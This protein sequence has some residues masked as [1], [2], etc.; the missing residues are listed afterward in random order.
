MK[1]LLQRTLALA[2]PHGI[3]LAIIAVI[4]ASSVG[5]AGQVSDSRPSSTSQ[6]QVVILGTGTPQADPD[7]SGPSVAV[8]AG[9]TAYLVDCGPGVVRRAAAAQ[10][11]GVAALVPQNIHVVF[12]THLHSDHTLG[13]PDLIFSPWVLGR[14]D[15]LEAY[16]PRGLQDM[17]DYIEKAWGKDIDVRTNGLEQANRTGY[18]VQVH[19]IAPGIVYKDKNVTVSAFLV[20]HGSWDQAFGYKF[21]TADRTIVISG[22]TAPTDSVVKACNRCDV[23]LHEAYSEGDFSARTPERQKYFRSFHTSSAELAKEATQAQ[24]RLLVLYHQMYGANVTYD[25]LLGEVKQHYSGNAVSAHD[26]D[27]Y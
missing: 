6:T 18:K 20:A 16:G 5:S 25:Q 3:Y 23:L 27:V 17:T 15:P 13:Y 19:E 8:I 4:F 2:M 12:I 26:L 9:G 21:E 7:N 11:K 1:H 22:D 14:S 24:P 10:R